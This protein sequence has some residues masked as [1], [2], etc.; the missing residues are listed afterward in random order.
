VVHR[1]YGEG[2]YD[3]RNELARTGPI[4]D[5]SIEKARSQFAG[6]AAKGLID[7]GASAVCISQR[8][9]D[10]LDLPQVDEDVLGVVGGG[11]VPTKIYAGYLVVPALDF[12]EITQLHAVNMR[13]GNHNVL[14][15][16]SFLSHFIVTFDGPEGMFHFARPIAP[17]EPWNDDF[18]T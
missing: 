10:Q 6:F 17:P 15:G 13:N 11:T 3:R 1:T 7:T 14:L 4:I 2:G 16:R 9:A 8:I 5:I 12:R 18:A